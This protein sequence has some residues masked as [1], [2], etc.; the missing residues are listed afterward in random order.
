[1][2][3]RFFRKEQVGAIKRQVAID[4]VRTYLMVALDA[5]FAAG[6]HQ[7]RRPHDVRFKEKLRIFDRTIDV[8]FGRKVDDH[9]G[10]FFFK[11]FVDCFTVADVNLA[12]TEVG[13]VHHRLERRQ[14]ARI[15]ELVN[16]DY[17]IIR[18]CLKHVEHEVASY[19][20]GSA[21]NDDIQSDASLIVILQPCITHM[22]LM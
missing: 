17:A 1:M 21:C 14:V 12:E 8:R 9:V 13:I 16:A 22:H 18:M 6:V 4:F 10:M 15:R 20:A 3:R 11:K 7:N 19:E 5:V 2:D